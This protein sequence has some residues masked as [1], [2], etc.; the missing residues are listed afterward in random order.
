MPFVDHHHAHI[1]KP[2]GTS[3]LGQQ[4]MDGLRRCDEHVRQLGPL[5]RLF[6]G[7]GVPRPKPH[8]PRQ[9]HALSHAF[10]RGGNVGRQ[11]PQWS[12]PEQLQSLLMRMATSELSRCFRHHMAH[13][14][15]RLATACWRLKKSALPLSTGVP[16]LLLK[17]LRHPALARK[18]PVQ[19]DVDIWNMGSG[20]WH[21]SP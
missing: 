5:L 10:C 9:A 4:N 14:C 15:V 2:L 3:L 20:S 19:G 1:A 21:L 7:R 17:V 8:L 13:G 11:S 18:P 6:F 16:H 12:D